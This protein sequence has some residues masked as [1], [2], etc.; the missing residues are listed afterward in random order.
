MHPQRSTFTKSMFDEPKDQHSARPEENSTL[1]HRDKHALTNRHVSVKLRLK[2]FDPIMSPTLLFGLAS[3]PLTSSHFKKIDVVQ[4]RMIRAIVGW[5][6][7]DKFDWGDTMRRMNSKVE[8]ALKTFL[9]CSW[10]NSVFKRSFWFAARVANSNTW[11]RFATLWDPLEN[12]RGNFLFNAF[13]C[14]WSATEKMG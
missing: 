11:P 1:T 5:V 12:W 6:A 10:S 14:P 2:Y 8:A 4:R 3:L 9:V 7:V 13:P